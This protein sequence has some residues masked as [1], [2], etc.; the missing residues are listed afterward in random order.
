MNIYILPYV[1]KITNKLTDEFYIGYRKL[2]QKLNKSPENDMF[3][4]YFSSG[5]MK[6]LIKENPENYTF[7]IL[8]QSG[9]TV[10]I[11]EKEEHVVY[12]YEQLIIRENIKN[13][14]CKNK[15]FVDP[16]SSNQSF[17]CFGHSKKTIEKIRK[18][19]REVTWSH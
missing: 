5:K 9:E 18:S 4:T 14:L 1:Y 3:K 12:W 8:F 19:V 6:T 11:N 15:C 16:D 10:K 17:M 2:N 7:N 13:P